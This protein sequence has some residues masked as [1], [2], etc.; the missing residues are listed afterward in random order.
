MKVALRGNR[1]TLLVIINEEKEVKAHFV[2]ST[3]DILINLCSDTII[4][5][6]GE[7]HLKTPILPA[8]L[9]TE[10]IREQSCHHCRGQVP[11]AKKDKRA[12]TRFDPNFPFPALYDK[13]LSVIFLSPA[14]G[15]EG[16]VLFLF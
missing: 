6:L 2:S 16:G 13:E 1:L 11:P 4:I 14:Q 8:Y 9:S 12:A 5:R 3:R 10:V 7:M 15:L